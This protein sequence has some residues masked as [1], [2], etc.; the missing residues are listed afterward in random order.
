MSK[1]E[2]W[3]TIGVNL[4]NKNIIENKYFLLF[5]LDN[6]LESKLFEYQMVDQ[7]LM[8]IHLVFLLLPNHHLDMNYVL[9]HVDQNVD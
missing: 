7:D 9:L 8:E 4:E 6:V 3:L 1:C 2:P 5:L